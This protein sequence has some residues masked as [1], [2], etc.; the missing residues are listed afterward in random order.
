MKH[1]FVQMLN[2]TQTDEAQWNFCPHNQVSSTL[3]KAMSFGSLFEDTV[4]LER[5]FSR[6][7]ICPFSAYGFNAH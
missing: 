1:K 6:G 4:N 2:V 7:I 3:L 5:T